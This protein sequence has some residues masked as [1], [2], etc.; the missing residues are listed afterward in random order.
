MAIGLSGG[1]GWFGYAASS[2]ALAD[3]YCKMITL[4]LA[5]LY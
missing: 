3:A 5:L 2:A 1:H 4:V